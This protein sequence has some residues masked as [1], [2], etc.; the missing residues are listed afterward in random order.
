MYW[1]FLEN[2]VFEN[3]GK[4]IISIKQKR[5]NGNDDP[6]WHRIVTDSEQAQGRSDLKRRLQQEPLQ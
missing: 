2:L 6:L 4:L 1:V 5:P 3:C